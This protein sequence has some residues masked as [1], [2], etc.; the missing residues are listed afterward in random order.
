MK[1]TR[2]STLTISHYYQVHKNEYR[3]DRVAG[4]QQDGS[5]PEARGRTAQ[6][7]ST[8]YCHSPQFLGAYLVCFVGLCA[9]IG[10]GEEPLL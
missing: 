9:E 8:G 7:I 3:D 1:N 10:L 4:F 5:T 2:L 6:N